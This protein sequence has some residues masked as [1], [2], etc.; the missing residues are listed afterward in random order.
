MTHAAAPSIQTSSLLPSMAAA[1]VTAHTSLQI[2]HLLP[3]CLTIYIPIN[4]IYDIF[5]IPCVLY[6]IKIDL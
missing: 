6:M 1:P 2:I 3:D 4:Y 5:P